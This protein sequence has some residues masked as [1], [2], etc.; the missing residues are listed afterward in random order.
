MNLDILKGFFLR[1]G[2]GGGGEVKVFQ[3]MKM[4]VF[5]MI[6]MFL[7]LLELGVIFF[8]WGI[9]SFGGVKAYSKICC[10]QLFTSAIKFLCI[11]ILETLLHVTLKRRA[12]ISADIFTRLLQCFCLTCK[13]LTT[14]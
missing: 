2:G 4:L 11:G 7:T 5:A 12:K 10:V 1:G 14:I 13:N 8:R 6:I 3:P 9:N